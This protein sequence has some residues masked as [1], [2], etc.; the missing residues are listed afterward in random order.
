MLRD[1][2]STWRKNNGFWMIEL[3]IGGLFERL[4]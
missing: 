1:E 4:V 3:D 2:R